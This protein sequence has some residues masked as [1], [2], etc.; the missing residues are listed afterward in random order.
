[1]NDT[2]QSPL[3][4][5]ANV[6]LLKEYTVK[7]LVS[8]WSSDFEIDI[9]C[10]LKGISEIHLYRCEDSQLEFFVPTS[11]EGS[12]QLYTDL[13]KFDWFYIHDKWEFDQAIM[14][15]VGSHNILEVG[16]G[17]GFFIS[18]VLKHINPTSI[19]GV[20]LSS[21]AV[22]KAQNKGIP[23]AKLDIRDMASKAER[24]DAICS[25]HVLEHVCEP[26]VFI[27]SL[28]TLLNTNGTLILCVPNKDSFIRFTK[29]LLDLPPHHMTRW[30]IKSF[31]YLE[32]LFP[33]TLEKVKFEPLPDYHIHWFVSTY[34][35]LFQLRV[36]FGRFMFGRH[37]IAVLTWVLEK[38]GLNRF[39]HG[40]GIY[41]K[42]RKT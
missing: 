17:Q 7:D 29:N 26:K 2:I 30:G 38:T 20:E 22:T 25:F 9:S 12:S 18:K 21:E 5:S 42:Y 15:I 4:P 39:F 16:C 11:A 13:Q 14:D 24:F 35:E 41:V 1:M 19:L 8:A 34:A 36:P 3:S 10:E 33:L 28:V 40:Q 37:F 6:N 27:E 23:V 31:E 32:T